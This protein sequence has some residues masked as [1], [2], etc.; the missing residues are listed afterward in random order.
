MAQEENVEKGEKRTQVQEV[1]VTGGSQSFQGT[2][3]R[4]D[5]NTKGDNS[6]K[7]ENIVKN[8]KL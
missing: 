4:K 8:V 1:S 2:R 6:L 3:K 7:K 5:C